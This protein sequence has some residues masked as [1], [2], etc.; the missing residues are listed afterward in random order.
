M[1][2][3]VPSVS[4]REQDMYARSTTMTVDGELEA[5]VAMVRDEVW[6]AVQAMDG[7]MGFSLMVDRDGGRMIA[8]SSWASEEA[9]WGSEAAV[10]GLRER[11]Q[12]VTGGAAPKVE[13]WEIAAMHRDH[14]TAEGTCVRA[15][16]TRVA[17]DLVPDAIEYYKFLLLPQVQQLEGFCSASLLVNRAIGLGVSSV[18]FDSRAAMEATRDEG[19]AVREASRREAG[20]EILEVAE[21]D[22]ALAHLHVP[23]LV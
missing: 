7:C 15:T 23:E 4:R 10:T 8:T 3:G 1:P 9:M 22:L 6:P 13:E 11:V 16:W 20:V 21:F 18:A 19:A 2:H 5:G 17:P 14:H 12:A